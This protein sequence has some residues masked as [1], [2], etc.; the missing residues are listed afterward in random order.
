MKAAIKFGPGGLVP[1]VAGGTM[2]TLNRR[3]DCGKKGSLPSWGLAGMMKADLGGSGSA[4]AA[5]VL[6]A[7]GLGEAAGVWAARAAK[8]RPSRPAPSGRV[9]VRSERH[10]ESIRRIRGLR[11]GWV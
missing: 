10:G 6:A 4:G 11:T 9:Q 1:V 3:V 2:G 8:A 5:L 7:A